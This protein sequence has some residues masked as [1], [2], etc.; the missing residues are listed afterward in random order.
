MSCDKVGT[1]IFAG[2]TGCGPVQ[3][4]FNPDFLKSY[5]MSINIKNEN[6]MG[7][8][9]GAVLGSV[10]SGLTN[11]K[12]AAAQAGKVFKP[13]K[14]VF[15]KLIGRLTGRTK[16]AEVSKQVQAESQAGITN[17]TA[18]NLRSQGFPISGQISVGSDRNELLKVLGLIGAV[19][20][21]IFYFSKPKKG[22]RRRR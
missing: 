6:N 3:N 17:A 18:K 21:G 13:P 10:S 2:N 14:T 12:V 7:F 5:P 16:A 20:V 11:Q 8:P 22:R 19:I 15:G 9:L 4:P 1:G